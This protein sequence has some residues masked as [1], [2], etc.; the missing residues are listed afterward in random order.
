[1]GAIHRMALEAG[2]VRFGRSQLGGIADVAFAN[3]F[4]AGFGVL[5]AVRVTDLTLSAA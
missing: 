5:V 2:P 4:G 3:S 1:M